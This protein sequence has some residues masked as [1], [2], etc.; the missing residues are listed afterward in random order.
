VAAGDEG[1]MIP[2]AGK[3][4]IEAVATLTYSIVLI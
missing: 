3:A 2:G 4:V 1:A